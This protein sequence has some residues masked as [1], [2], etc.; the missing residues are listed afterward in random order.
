MAK[1]DYSKWEPMLRNAYANRSIGVLKKISKESGIPVASLKY[2]ARAVLRLH[3][4]LARDRINRP[5]EEKEIDILENHG[6]KSLQVIRGKLK[7][8]G[9]SR[10]LSAIETRLAL[11]RVRATRTEYITLAD[12]SVRMGYEDTMAARRWE[13]SGL[14][15]SRKQVMTERNN[16]NGFRYVSRK[17][18]RDFL[19]NHPAA[20]DH[21]RIDWI[22]ALDI[23]TGKDVGMGA[24]SD[25][26]GNG[27]EIQQA[28]AGY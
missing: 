14:I 28:T 23:L 9:F 17:S 7:R 5:W 26:C 11:L 6:E 12:F 10:S 18:I 4:M 25:S 3:P 8:C 2:H 22:W 13:K 20:Y 27:Y 15:K 1:Y 21:R 16:G 24:I 19:L